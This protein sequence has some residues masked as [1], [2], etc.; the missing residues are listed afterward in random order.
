MHNP[1]RPARHYRPAFLALALTLGGW[2]VVGHGTALDP[3]GTAPLTA[4]DWWSPEGTVSLL[5]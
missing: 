1:V 3:H 5:G 2:Y 4:R